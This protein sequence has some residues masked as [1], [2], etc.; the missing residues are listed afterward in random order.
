MQL[1]FLFH[2]GISIS[3]FAQKN[4]ET[5]LSNF[6][7]TGDNEKKAKLLDQITEYYFLARNLDSLV[8]YGQEAI[9]VN[10]KLHN[11]EAV[12]KNQLMNSKAYLEKADVVNSER[13]LK[14]AFAYFKDKHDL[15]R[16][17][18]VR[19]IQGALAQHKHQYESSA[20]YF[21]E[22]IDL[23]NRGNSGVD[24]HT[25][26][27]A[28]TGLFGTY[29]LSQQY[30]RALKTTD[31]YFSFIQEKY[32]SEIGSAHMQLGNLYTFTFNPEKA[33]A[34]FT[35]ARNFYAQQQNQA[36]VA[37]IN[38]QLGITL[39][40]LKKTD[41][42]VLILNQA[43]DFFKSTKNKMGES[44]SLYGL[45]AM[46]MEKK[47]F[48]QAN[49][50]IEEAIAVSPPNNPIAAY[51][52][53][54]QNKIRL[55]MLMAD[56]ADLAHNPAKKTALKMAAKEFEDAFEAVAAQKT[57]FVSPHELIESR[58]LLADAYLLLADYKAAYDNYK[59][60]V[61]LKDSIFGTSKMRSLNAVEAELGLERERARIKLEEA[62]KLLQLQKEMELEA[63]R[64]EYERKQ[65]AA[66]TEEER[67]QLLHEEELRRKEIELKYAEKQ[68][69]I[70]LKF[71]QEKEIA[72]IQQEKKDAVAA[73]ELQSTRNVRN[74]SALGVGLATLLLGI[75]GWSYYQKRKDNKRIALEKHKSDELLLN[76]LPQEV[77]E[78]LKEKGS[79]SAQQHSNVSVLFTDFVNFTQ[80]SEKL[81]VEELV[82]ELNIN[83]TAFDRIMEKHGLEKIKTI[84]DAYLAVSGLPTNNPDHAQNA[85][86]AAKEIIEFIDARRIGNN[87]ALEIRIGIHSGPVIAGIVGVKKFAYDIWGDTVNTAARMEQSSE[88][89]RIN[90]SKTTYEMAKDTFTFEPRG[91]V[92]TKG[93]GQLEMYFVV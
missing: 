92:E 46:A 77:A 41:S 84:G 35:K 89:G 1:V 63:L 64:H 4:I 8:Y 73:A 87:K 6:N 50:F 51:Y 70:S 7:A 86:R 9:V 25:L 32:P 74:L 39:A 88:K 55:N 62:T 3:G 16:Y 82:R 54:H 75:T 52:P 10:E 42:A 36:A 45:S 44:S 30:E 53:S 27:S 28:Y 34:E 78:E 37:S 57:G 81:G 13:Y 31:K 2:M 49:E 17:A 23:Y 61:T 79:T 20:E 12:A 71:E 80:A 5:L 19:Y 85:I 67:Q 14:P 22:I 33:A 48:Q 59:S 91:M 21:N 93:K 15:M 58:Q 18:R 66:E 29:T 11:T 72:R 60:S 68:K 90:I 83:F 69:E 38:L 26:Y 56:S 65:A 40:S 47:Q 76:I 43:R 24:D